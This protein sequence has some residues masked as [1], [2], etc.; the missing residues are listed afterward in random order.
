MPPILLTSHPAAA[1]LFL[2]HRISTS[3]VL[4]VR[5]VERQVLDVEQLL[6]RPWHRQQP[7]TGRHR[8][9]DPHAAGNTQDML[10]VSG[11]AWCVG[12][13]RGRTGVCTARGAQGTQLAAEEGSFF[14]PGF[15]SFP[16]ICRAAHPGLIRCSLADRLAPPRGL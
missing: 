12:V 3:Q 9:A 15:V 4:G 10:C 11:D 1:A 5:K 6:V 2:S 16:G 13:V 7:A 8:W 14:I